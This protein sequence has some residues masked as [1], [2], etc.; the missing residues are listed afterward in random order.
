MISTDFFPTLWN[1]PNQNNLFTNVISDTSITGSYDNENFPGMY[2]M[3]YIS[4]DDIPGAYKP[5]YAHRSEDNTKMIFEIALDPDNYNIGYTAGYIWQGSQPFLKNQF[6]QGGE[7]W[8]FYGYPTNYS[9]YLIS[10]SFINYMPDEMILQG[11]MPSNGSN[12]PI[13]MSGGIGSNYSMIY[14]G[15]FVEYGNTEALGSYWMAECDCMKDFNTA[16][17]VV[18]F[19]QGTITDNITLTINGQS[20]PFIIDCSELNNDSGCAEKYIQNNGIYYRIIYG[21]TGYSFNPPAQ[22]VYDGSCNIIPSILVKDNVYRDGNYAGTGTHYT[23]NIMVN[24]TQVRE[25]RYIT[26]RND[27][28]TPLDAGYFWSTRVYGTYNYAEYVSPCG[29]YHGEFEIAA[30]R[31]MQQGQFIQNGNL[32][33]YRLNGNSDQL[34]RFERPEADVLR[35]LALFI[36]FSLY[37]D[38]GFIK[39]VT[40]IPKIESDNRF[41]GRFMTGSLAEL[42]QDLRPWQYGKW[43]DS[44]Y[45][46]ADKP[47]YKPPG[48][49]PDEEGEAPDEGNW[50]DPAILSRTKLGR[51]AFSHNEVMQIVGLREFASQ[52]WDAPADFWEALSVSRELSANINDYIIG[53]RAYPVALNVYNE[54]HVIHVGAGGEIDMAAAVWD[55]EMVNWLQLGSITIPRQY[56]NFLDYNPYTSATIFL[57]FAGT[58]E[59][60]PKYLYDSQINLFLTVDT[61]DG[62]GV[63]VVTNVDR[64]FPILIKQCK[65]GVDIPISGL[66]ATQMASNILNATMTTGQHAINTI[67]RIGG[68]AAGIGSGLAAPGP[69]MLAGLAT[70][71]V[72]LGVQALT[73]ATN[74]AMGNKEIPY[75][76]GGSGG[77]AAAEATYE[78]YITLRR[79]LCTN[80]ENYAHT[81]GNLVN[82]TASIGSLSGFTTCRNVDVG[83]ISQAVDKE[84]AQIKRI[85]EKGFYA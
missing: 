35:H 12:N 64:Q 33:M 32:I 14:F 53:C 55:S 18:D 21:I 85:L 17:Q 15:F 13:T 54:H 10:Y 49:D 84:K 30:I 79:P 60:N 63:W 61:T 7:P 27:T 39:D 42:V 9:D 62:S 52:L 57:P 78:P 41:T 45:D 22:R 82:K 8:K 25:Y 26:Y 23:Y 80:P 77:A 47:E 2:Y 20:V 5:Y 40:F 74:M 6:Y 16:K 66:N 34:Y 19:L 24:D 70:E 43:V 81:V 38:S 65:V 72:D 1:Y 71:T 59:I 4:S 68:T 69:G 76:T 56:K 83:G 3:G 75:Y 31:A 11:K 73:D 46:P 36:R 51:S 29:G 58:F 44:D 67:N 37:S 48:P 28:N 50:G